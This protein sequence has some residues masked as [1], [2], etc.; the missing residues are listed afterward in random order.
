MIGNNCHIAVAKNNVPLAIRCTEFGRFSVT[1]FAAISAYA[2]PL[3]TGQTGPRIGVRGDGLIPA[4]PTRI[5]TFV[6]RLLLAP[7]L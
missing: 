5:S 6:I 2:V 7:G 1:G 4:K 3:G